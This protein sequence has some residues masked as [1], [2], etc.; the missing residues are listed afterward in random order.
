MGGEKGRGGRR[1][2]EEMGRWKKVV[3]RERESGC[4][5]T[6]GYQSLMYCTIAVLFPRRDTENAAK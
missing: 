4:L 2:R 3:E 1:G 6:V 5:I